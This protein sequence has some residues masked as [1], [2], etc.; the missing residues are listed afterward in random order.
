M[1]CIVT[2]LQQI[3]I[4]KTVHSIG[5]RDGRMWIWIVGLL[6][7]VNVFVHYGLIKAQMKAKTIVLIEILRNTIFFM[8]CFYY[9]E[10]SKK[11]MSYKRKC[12][13]IITLFYAVVMTINVLLAVDIGIKIAAYTDDPKTN[14]YINPVDLCSTLEFQIFRWTSLSIAAVFQYTF[15]SIRKKIE[16]KPIVTI[17]EENIYQLQRNTLERLRISLV[18][19]TSVTWFL[20]F[21]DMF[22]LFLELMDESITNCNH[23]LFSGSADWLNNIQWFLTRLAVTLSSNFL[24]LFMFCKDRTKRAKPATNAAP[25]NSQISRLFGSDAAEM[26]RS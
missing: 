21:I 9:A 1:A 15:W 4:Y 17:F 18:F 7:A 13:H 23:S 26:L 20:I 6:Q 19:F 11:L 5:F 22:S 3:I 10:K 2:F 16:S 24:V 14:N 8:V 12:L 25:L